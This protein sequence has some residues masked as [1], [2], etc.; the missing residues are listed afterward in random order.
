MLK[1]IICLVNYGVVLLLGVVSLMAGSTTGVPMSPGYGGYQATAAQEYYTTSSP[2]YTITSIYVTP[3]A[4][5]PRPSST[6]SPRMQSITR[7][8]TMLPATTLKP[9][10][11][12]TTTCATP[13]SCNDAP[14]YYSAPSFYTKAPYC[15][16]TTEAPEY[17]TTEAPEYYTTE[18][19]E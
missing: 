12:Y 7:K 19:T 8:L 3:A 16:N 2:Y 1:F 17:Y 5:T 4:R 6:T 9:R 15:N 11:N 13:E 14:K 18:A 10:S